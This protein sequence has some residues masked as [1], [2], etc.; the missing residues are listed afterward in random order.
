[1][2]L[3][4]FFQSERYFAAHA[5]HVRRVLT[6]LHAMEGPELIRTASIQVRRGDYAYLQPKHP[7]VPMSFYEQAMELL[8]AQGTRRFLV[9]SDDLD[10]CRSQA[11][12]SDVAVIP[13]LGVLDQFVQTMACEH[14]ILA[15][16]TFSW[17]TAWLDR[18]P[19]KIVIAP[20]AWFGEDFRN[21]F[22]TRD[23]YCPDWIVF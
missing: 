13:N 22:S 8:R 6:P 11:W 20:Q 10:W 14:H 3:Q 19:G 12:P 17:W 16:S 4:G 5:D 9:F 23:L 1:L 18:K 15:N 2:A 7:F 21:E